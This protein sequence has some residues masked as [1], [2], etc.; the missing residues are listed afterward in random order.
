MKCEKCGAEIQDGLRICS[1][2]GERIKKDSFPVWL[3]VVL[4]IVGS[5]LFILPF[6]GIVAAMT[7]PALM[8]NTESAKNKACYKKSL[9][10]LNQ[11]LL[12]SEAINDKTY[13]RFNDVWE[14]AVKARLANPR[15]IQNGLVMM[16]G[17]EIKYEKLGNPCVKVPPRPTKHSA[18]A[19]LT[20]DTNGFG[21][22]PNARTQRSSTGQYN[23]VKDQFNVLLYANSVVPEDGSVEEDIIKESR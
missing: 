17:T 20:I 7:L 9:S 23:D 13:S 18:C 1:N 19:V 15:D 10:S 2:C 8:S 22:A 21:K 4:I 5:G 14:I 6:I 16:D 12:M 3:I 11:A